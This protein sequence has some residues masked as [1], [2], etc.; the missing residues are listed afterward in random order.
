MAG[1]FSFYYIQK[2]LRV[3]GFEARNEADSDTPCGA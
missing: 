3:F 1:N 2:R